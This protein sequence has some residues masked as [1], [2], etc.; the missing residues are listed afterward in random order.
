MEAGETDILRSNW[1]G[2]HLSYCKS[3]VEPFQWERKG[4]GQCVGALDPSA[5]S[6][7]QL[8]SVFVYLGIPL[9]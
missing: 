4:I 3:A 9:L 6:Q 8:Y 7:L 2:S 5:S 1:T